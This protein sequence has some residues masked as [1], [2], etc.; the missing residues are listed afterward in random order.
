MDKTTKSLVSYS[1]KTGLELVSEVNEVYVSEIKGILKESMGMGLGLIAGA[2]AVYAFGI[3][4]VVQF[5]YYVI[6]VLAKIIKTVIA[7]LGELFG[8][9]KGVLTKLAASEATVMLSEGFAK[10]DICK[11][12]ESG[13]DEVSIPIIGYRMDFDVDSILSRL[14]SENYGTYDAIY[15]NILNE[16]EDIFDSHDH[17][18]SLIAEK[19]ARILN[20]PSVSPKMTTVE[21][22]KVLRSVVFGQPDVNLAYS[23]KDAKTI[24][25]VNRSKADHIQNLLKNAMVDAKNGL[26]ALDA[27]KAEIQR[28]PELT[29]NSIKDNFQI[30]LNWLIE[31]RTITM[32]DQI[33]IFDTLIK[34]IRMVDVQ[35]KLIHTKAVQTHLEV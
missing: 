8:I 2:A 20:V 19:R 16:A 9:C 12:L 5:L 17:M 30:Q 11:M 25:K 4:A 32:K 15:F 34:Y 24:S 23:Y 3:K 7:Q 33:L 22:A 35:T 6:I 21:F 14:G 18:L 10:V 13:P 26:R 31:Y 1:S 27:K 29:T 28:N